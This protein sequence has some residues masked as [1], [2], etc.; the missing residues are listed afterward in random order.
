MISSSKLTNKLLVARCFVRDRQLG[1]EH[2]TKVVTDGDVY[3]EQT[4]LSQRKNG[5]IYLGIGDF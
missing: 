3:G 2:T 4:G 1:N 5:M